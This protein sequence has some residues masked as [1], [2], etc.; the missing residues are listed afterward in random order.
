MYCLYKGLIFRFFFTNKPQHR[1][2][3]GELSDFPQP[4]PSSFL[5]LYKTNHIAAIS[6]AKLNIPI[7]ACLGLNIRCLL[8]LNVI[9]PHETALTVVRKIGVTQTHR[10]PANPVHTP[11][12]AQTGSSSVNYSRDTKE[13]IGVSLSGEL[14]KS[15]TKATS[16]YSDIVCGLDCRKHIQLCLSLAIKYIHIM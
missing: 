12:R 10:D 8:E 5:V 2:C 16:G 13:D 6:W 3:L 11:S 14:C 9:R 15:E 1:S 4:L 7:Q